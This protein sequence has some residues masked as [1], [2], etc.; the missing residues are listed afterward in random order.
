MKALL[1]RVLNASVAVDGEVCGQ[2][3]EGFLILLGVEKGD[4]EKD[5]AVLAEKIAKLRIF[6]D[7]ND[8]MNLSVTDIGGSVLV[9]SQ[10]TLCANYRHGNRPDF[11]NAAPP[12]EANA[13]YEHFAALMRE[14]LGEEKVATGV[15]GADMKVSLVNNGP[16][17]MMLESGVLRK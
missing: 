15:F 7:E 16:V 13:L 17:T 4:D 9:I 1:Q 12:A 10:F 8:K 2:C 3:G 14:K 11:L 6:R 5:A